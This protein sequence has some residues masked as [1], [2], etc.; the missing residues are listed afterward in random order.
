MYTKFSP[1]KPEEKKPCDICRYRWENNIKINYK[2]I[3][4]EGANW[5]N[6]ITDV[7]Y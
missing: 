2:L 4:Y 6:L 1:G 5:I 3:V 7:V